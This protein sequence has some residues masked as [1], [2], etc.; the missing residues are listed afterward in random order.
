MGHNE[1]K[2][3][4]EAVFFDDR[5]VIDKFFGLLQKDELTLT[6]KS[7]GKTMSVLYLLENKL[8]IDGKIY[9]GLYVY[10]AA[11][12]PEHRRKGH[13]ERLLGKA[14]NI[15]ES[16]NADF[17]SL[18]PAAEKLYHYYSKFGYRPVFKTEK[19][20]IEKSAKGF[21]V[22]TR[23]RTAPGLSA[24][25][26]IKIRENSLNIAG[27]PYIT[28]RENAAEFLFCQLKAYNG[29][30]L[31][32]NSAYIYGHIKDGRAFINEAASVAG[33][34]ADIATLLNDIPADSFE[35]RLPCGLYDI[36]NYG[37]DIQE[38]CIADG[39][40]ILPLS[41]ELKQSLQKSPHPYLGIT[42]E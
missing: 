16:K 18:Y 2:N 33:D 29:F 38:R 15:A 14:E 5:A 23:V 3:L 42:L 26:F 6:E 13:M 25:E 17:I 11:T 37:I 39:G 24:S 1:L 40:M 32:N 19:A 34:F 7:G 36:E 9:N 41:E 21:I 4:W 35:I 28:W 30:I 10:A 31:S 27:R 12:L 8:N 20:I 22:N